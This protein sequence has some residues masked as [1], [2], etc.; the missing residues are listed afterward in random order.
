MAEE[1]LIIRYHQSYLYH[2]II[3]VWQRREC[4]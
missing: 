3:R 2:F 4:E 1:K